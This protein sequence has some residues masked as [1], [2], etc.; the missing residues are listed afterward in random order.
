MAHP[1]PFVKSF[2]SPKVIL[3]NSRIHGLGMFAKSKIERG[4]IVFI[5][6]GH[7]V[8]KSE[9]YFDRPISSY[10]PIDDQY[11]IGATQKDEEEGIK[12]YLNHSC[13]PNCGLRG[14]ITFVA[15]NKIQEGKELSCDY[16]MI[17]NE[18]YKFECNCGSYSCRKLITGFDWKIKELQEKY[19]NYFARYLLDKISTQCPNK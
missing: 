1:Y 9:L 4:E 6:G 17:D 11:F 3:G 15:L 19:A 18:D 16:A 14:E 12:L 2:I 8:R 5:K 10:L 13:E 7:I